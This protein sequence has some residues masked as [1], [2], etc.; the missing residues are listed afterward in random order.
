MHYC[1]IVN[2]VCLDA[3]GTPVKD[4]NGAVRHRLGDTEVRHSVP[5]FMLYPEE[6]IQP[7]GIQPLPILSGN[8]AL[9]LRAVRDYEFVDLDGKLCKRVAGDLY[10]FKGPGTYIPRV[11]EVIAEELLAA[12][13]LPGEAVRLRASSDFVDRT[14][15]RR[16]AG[17]EW[18]YEEPGAFLPSIEEQVVEKIQPIILTDKVALH[19]EAIHDFTDR[20]GTARRTGEQWLVTSQRS[21]SFLMTPDQRLLKREP[22]T[23]LEKNSYCVVVNAWDATDRIQLGQREL[24]V[25]PRS[26]F[27]KPGE[28]LE[29]GIQPAY[30]LGDNE[31]VLVKALVDFVDGVD[32]QQVRRRAGDHWMVF[33][34]VT[35]VPRVAEEVLERRSAIPLAENE[36]LYVRNTKSGKISVVKGCT[37]LLAADEVLWEKEL[38]AV[39]E[40]KL[41]KQGLSY[42][43]YI[44]SGPSTRRSDRIKWRLVSYQ[45]PHNAVAQVYN[46][47]D[48]VQRII[49]G[50]DLVQLGPDEEFC[51]LSL[52]GSEWLPAQP[53]VVTPKKSGLIRTLYLFL[54]PESMS[55][56][57]EVETADHARLKLQL[58]YSWHF[59]VK[60]GDMEAGRQVFNVPDFVG[61]TCSQLQSRIRAAV[62]SEPF[63]VFHRNSARIITC[64]V[65]G[66]DEKGQLGSELRFPANRLVITSVDI[67]EVECIDRA[68]RES[69]QKSVKLAIEITTA[70]QEQTA[71]QLAEEKNQVAQG[72]LERQVLKDRSEAERER[73]LLLEFLAESAAIETTGTSKA[74]AKANAE[75]QR[76]EGESEVQ[77]AL[78]K[79][80][81]RRLEFEAELEIAERRREADLAHLAAV[82]DLEIRKRDEM[83]KVET[84]KFQQ[85]VE[86]VGQSTIAAM[87]RAGP[88][89]QA[90]LL[91]GLGLQ[92]YLM[93][94]GT[95][96]INLMN[97]ATS[98]IGKA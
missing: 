21:E 66:L 50:P 11:Q 71:R 22:I 77:M 3:R 5:P 91:K 86:S 27:L 58:S 45:L 95:S 62:A 10:L 52:S 20:W 44:Q 69:L 2:P 93:T 65:F 64:A 15:V 98:L 31:A 54:G 26:F 40:E 84:A 63:D 29:A 75:R 59:D 18:L 55:D 7:P 88:E 4:P 48:R 23:L 90:R 68:T 8:K 87:A 30:L 25:G 82:N 9:K 46:F 92:G 32:A 81:S 83:A 61:D 24:R 53:N 38:P 36:G 97:T 85:C 33:G 57:L 79:A 73:K 74:E 16:N 76:I 37:Y 96:P 60:Y 17:D 47:T 56:V 89:M 19:M 51:V 80:E 13:V 41:A 42:S 1:I 34:P 70:S 6:Q 78:L 14:G 12:T 72:E 35:F 67:Q 49:F 94:D 43:D 39:V 28:A